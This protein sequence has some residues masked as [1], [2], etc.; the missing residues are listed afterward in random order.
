MRSPEEI[1]AQIAKTERTMNFC[2][3]FLAG[4]IVGGLV[5]LS[6]YVL[7]PEQVVAATEFPTAF[8][9][10]EVPYDGI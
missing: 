6:G 7:T 2:F 10:M 4:L 3:G 5:A 8:S 1:R 9:A